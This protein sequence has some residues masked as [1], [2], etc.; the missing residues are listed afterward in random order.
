MINPEHYIFY[1]DKN[2]W[3]KKIKQIKFKD[4]NENTMTMIDVDDKL[5]EQ[6]NEM[7]ERSN[8]TNIKI[9]YKNKP[10]YTR[11]IV[12]VKNFNPTTMELIYISKEEQDKIDKKITNALKD[13]KSPFKIISSEV[14]DT[15]AGLFYNGKIDEGA[16]GNYLDTTLDGAKKR[17]VN[18]QNKY[19]HAFRKNSGNKV[20]LQQH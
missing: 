1:M 9:R 19:G 4:F 10:A 12:K 8:Y 17:A 5:I 15:R 6:F 3:K 13:G 11:S 2:D 20:K 14:R 16:V 7:A 18:R